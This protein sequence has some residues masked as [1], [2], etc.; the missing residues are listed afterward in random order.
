MDKNRIL[1]KNFKSEQLSDMLEWKSEPRVW[2]V[3]K[4]SSKLVLKTDEG[5]DFWQ[6]THYGFQVDNGHFLFAK[7]NKN[8]RMTTK[9]E[10]LP[11]SK[12]DQAGLMRL[13]GKDLNRIY[14]I[15]FQ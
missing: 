14:S 2:F 15:W 6:R 5:T 11:K 8:F 7:T 1:Y 10:A 4:T 12:Y 13:M 3:D 9:V